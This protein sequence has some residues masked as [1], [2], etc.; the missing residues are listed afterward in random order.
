MDT[1]DRGGIMRPRPVVGEAAVPEAVRRLMDNFDYPDRETPAQLVPII[2]AAAGAGGLGAYTH[3]TRGATQ[4]IASAGEPIEWDTQF[5]PPVG[6][7]FSGTDIVI[8][9]RGYYNVDV[10]FDWSSFEGGG[11]VSVI[12]TRGGSDA[13]VWP[14]DDDPGMWTATDGTKFQGVAPAIPCRAGDILKVNIN[15]DDASAQTL[16]TAVCVTYLVDTADPSGIIVVGSTANV[17]DSGG[18]T[19]V[20]VTAPSATLPGD[21]MVAFIFSYEPTVTADTEVWTRHTSFD[22]RDDLEYIIDWKVADSDDASKVFQWSG[23]GG[24]TNKEVGVLLLVLRGVSTITPLGTVGATDGLNVTSLA[25]STSGVGNMTLVFGGSGD[26]AAVITH[27]VAGFVEIIE[28]T[29]IP[30]DENVALSAHTL[31]GGATS[32]TVAFSGGTVDDA[33]GFIVPVFAEN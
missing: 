33:I 8:E 25:L 31:T 16:L 2:A 19:T 32:A 29:E 18:T 23:S 15:P 21:I 14:P 9:R 3:L 1:G 28:Y 5:I 13:T 11:T 6:V 7:S 24:I 27:A 30:G 10:G 22:G 20:S 4:S 26:D 12:R 17:E